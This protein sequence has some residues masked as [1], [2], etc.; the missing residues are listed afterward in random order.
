MSES[1]RRIFATAGISSSLDTVLAT[2]IGTN[3]NNHKNNNHKKSSSN[4]CSE[5]SLSNN[6]SKSSSGSSLTLTNN[7]SNNAVNNNVSPLQ[8]PHHQFYNSQQTISTSANWSNVNIRS[9]SVCSQ[10]VSLHSSDTKRNFRSLNWCQHGSPL[11]TLIT[12]ANG[13]HSTEIFWP[14]RNN[15]NNNKFCDTE[16]KK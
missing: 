2:A 14:V 16:K 8:F 13:E 6:S 4:L 15:N 1:G 3:Y 5:K 7:N 12:C 10:K 11:L 9:A